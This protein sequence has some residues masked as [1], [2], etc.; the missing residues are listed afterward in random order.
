LADVIPRVALQTTEIHLDGTQYMLTYSDPGSWLLRLQ[1][2]QTDDDLEE[3]KITGVKPLAR[4]MN[5][6]RINIEGRLRDASCKTRG[7]E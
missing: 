2:D 1:L 5:T 3:A 7:V 4:W 6:T